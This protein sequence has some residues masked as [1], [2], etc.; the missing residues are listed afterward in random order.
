MQSG[1]NYIVWAAL[2]NG[3]IE[4]AVRRKD[5]RFDTGENAHITDDRRQAL[6]HHRKVGSRC[7]ERWTVVGE[8]KTFQSLLTDNTHYLEQGV[9]SAG[10]AY[11]VNME[12]AFNHSLSFG[13]AIIHCLHYHRY[14]SVEF[15][16]ATYPIIISMNIQ[17]Y[18]SRLYSYHSN[19]S[20]QKRSP[21]RTC[22]GYR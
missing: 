8:G 5:R 1:Y 15:L 2:E 13:F 3:Y 4:I 16:T 21:Q 18:N 7:G 17:T 22:G 11:R 6:E 19:D 20:R 14:C 9:K 12:I 10:A